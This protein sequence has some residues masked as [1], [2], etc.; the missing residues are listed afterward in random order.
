M[1]SRATR[2]FLAWLM[3]V[4]VLFAQSAALAYGC[5]LDPAVGVPAATTAP[6][7]SHVADDNAGGDGGQRNLC[8]I[9]CQTPTT[10]DPG[11]SVPLLGAVDARSGGITAVP[12]SV[13]RVPALLPPRSAP[14]PVLQRTSRLLI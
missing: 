3:A 7:P 9:H 10:A 1:K 12:S 13:H 8:Q 2:R 14:P 5:S 6:C 4:C 11:V